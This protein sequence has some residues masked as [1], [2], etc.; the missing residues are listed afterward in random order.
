MG[1]ASYEAHLAAVCG[2]LPIFW[3]VLKETWN[4]MFVTVTYEVH[5]TEEYE[6]FPSRHG[7]GATDLELQSTSSDRGITVMESTETTWEPFV[8][9]E[10]TGLGK[11]TTVVEAPNSVKWPTKVKGVLLKD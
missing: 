6:S 9:D 8:G 4:R 7:G 5:V 11:N 1:L 10:T 3:P 2:A